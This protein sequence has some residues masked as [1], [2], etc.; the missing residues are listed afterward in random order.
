MGQGVMEIEI[1]NTRLDCLTKP[2]GDVRVSEISITDEF[3]R[4]EGTK[5]IYTKDGTIDGLSSGVVSAE[6]QFVRDV[7]D[8]PNYQKYYD[9]PST[10]VIYS[11]VTMLN[12]Y[13]SATEYLGSS[14]Y[15][16][17]TPHKDMVNLTKTPVKEADPNIMSGKDEY[18]RSYD[19]KID[20][21]TS[22]I[23]QLKSVSHYNQINEFESSV[24]YEYADNVYSKPYGDLG[25]YTEG[26]VLT[27]FTYKEENNEIDDR[28]WHFYR[29]TKNHFPTIPQAVTFKDNYSE[30][31]VEN[32]AYSPITGTVLETEYYDAWGAKYRTKNVPAYTLPEYSDMGSKTAN[33][34]NKNMLSQ[35]AGEY[36][37]TYNEDGSE[38]LVSASVTTWNKD[39]TYR[40]LS[41]SGTTS[42]YADVSYTNEVYRSHKNYAWKSELNDDGTY[43]SFTDFDHNTSANNA[44]WEKISEVTLYDHYSRALE[45]EDINGDKAATKYDVSGQFNLLSS[46]NADYQEI[47]FSG[48]ELDPVNN[49]LSD[50]LYF[51]NSSSAIST[52]Y[53]HT[54]ASS[55]KLSGA[56][57]PYANMDISNHETFIVSAWVHTSNWTDAT[58]LAKFYAN[59]NP[60]PINSVQASGVSA[61]KFKAGDW[62]LLYMEIPLGSH[63]TADRMVV[64]VEN[65]NTNTPIYVD[66]FKLTPFESAGGCNVYDP[67]TFKV[68]AILDDQ[69][70]ATA[71]EY[72]D[73]GILKTV[74]QEVIDTPTLSGGFK[75]VKEYF[76]NYGKNN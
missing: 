75:T 39:W 21:Q 59:E 40:E 44:G 12:N 61:Q 41:T 32:T 10:G 64:S 74:K 11:K 35:S 66:D 51:N 68:A 48:F 1:K 69:H 33:S 15:E 63:S 22:G 23:G 70:L 24:E 57:G 28:R 43:A 72:D 14:V 53:A 62:Y 46:A 4:S 67:E 58:L 31:R 65:S 38:D 36:L 37:Y 76:Y 71:Y 52:D 27:D 16:F 26:N 18:A 45:S 60:T 20:I 54:G 73:N 50:N 5:Y 25:F 29:T 30:K 7:D 47:F 42:N 6:P 56:E 3:N 49:L 19:F 9:Y 2:G 8:I 13:Q 55:L 17:I 34:S